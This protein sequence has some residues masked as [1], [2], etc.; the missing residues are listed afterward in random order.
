MFCQAIEDVH[1]EE[2][3]TLKKILKYMDKSFTV[4]FFLEMIVKQSA[5]GLKKYF[6][7]AWCWLDFII[8]AVSE[9]SALLERSR[10]HRIW[11]YL[12]FSETEMI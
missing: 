8:V 11:K 10:F 4:I 7:D 1:I 12:A 5:Y 3:P 6:T 2:R 9:F